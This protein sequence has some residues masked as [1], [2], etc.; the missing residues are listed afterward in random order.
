LRGVDRYLEHRK[1]LNAPVWVGET[2]ERDST[3]YWATTDYFEA[4]NIGWSFWPWKKMDTVNTPYSIKRPQHWDAVAA[5]SRGEA[6]P[7]REVAQKAFDEF[8]TNI[9]LENC[10]YSPEMVNA[11]LRRV[12]ARIE[13]ENY[14]HAGPGV[15]YGV[16]DAARRSQY[17]RLDEPVTI[18]VREAQR[19]RTDQFIILA[20]TEWTAYQIESDAPRT[21]TIAL[22]VRAEAAP[23]KALLR[24]NEQ[25]LEVAVSDKS[26]TEIRLN[27]IQLQRG[28]NKLKWAVQ[29]G[30]MELDWL[31]AQ[32]SEESKQAVGINPPATAN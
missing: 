24:V 2:G 26:W 3:I 23:A 12:P 6:K 31:D 11:M 17:Y 16:K 19:P 28:I 14:G 10:T 15:S 7:T 5:Y 9:R 32:S 25:T 30:M 21:A 4:N 20:A 29:Q 22:R 13:A 27:A 8:L 18:K 1:R